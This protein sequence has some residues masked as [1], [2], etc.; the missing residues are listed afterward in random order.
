VISRPRAGHALERGGLAR[1]CG[2]RARFGQTRA[3]REASA[4]RAR[5]DRRAAK[6]LR[7]SMVATAM[8][9]LD[10]WSGPQRCRPDVTEYP[11]PEIGGVV[12]RRQEASNGGNP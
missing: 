2:N 10:A 11:A 1:S 9:T 5:L 4:K 8:G 6:R 7:K 3:P 12:V